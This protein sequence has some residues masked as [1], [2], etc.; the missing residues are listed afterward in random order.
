MMVA[1]ESDDPVSF[2]VVETAAQGFFWDSPLAF[3]AMSM[4][5]SMRRSGKRG[6]GATPKTL[7]GWQP[8]GG[9]G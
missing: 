4:S 6:T 2:V 3:I 8:G 5:I 9:G 1:D 7:P